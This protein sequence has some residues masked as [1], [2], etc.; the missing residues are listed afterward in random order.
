MQGVLENLIGN[1]TSC[2]FSWWMRALAAESGWICSRDVKHGMSVEKTP[3]GP[4]PPLLPGGTN[5]QESA[6]TDKKC[7]NIGFSPRENIKI[8]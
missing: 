8:S 7:A 3:G 2:I 4:L 1:N 6:K 5:E